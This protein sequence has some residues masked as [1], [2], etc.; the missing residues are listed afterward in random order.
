MSTPLIT[1]KPDYNLWE[2]AQTMKTKKIHKIPVEKDNRLVGII[3]ATDIVRLHSL[4]TGSEICKITE[5]VL[6]RVSPKK[7]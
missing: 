7:N 2:L 4:A 3:T 6:M 5:Q 1:A